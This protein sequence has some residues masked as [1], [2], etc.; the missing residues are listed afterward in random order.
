VYERALENAFAAR[1]R[2]PRALERALAPLGD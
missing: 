1:L 2:S